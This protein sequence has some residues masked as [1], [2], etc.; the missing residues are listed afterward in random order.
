M[1][2]LLS[3]SENFSIRFFIPISE[4][5]KDGLAG[6]LD[7]APTQNT[8]SVAEPEKTNECEMIGGDSAAEIAANLVS[9]IQATKL[10]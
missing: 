9:S 1:S 6:S 5:K 10:I 3:L 7:D 8:V 4:L 2:K